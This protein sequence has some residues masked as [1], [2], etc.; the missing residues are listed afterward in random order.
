MIT[1]QYEA[2]QKKST[3]R[4]VMLQRFD[5]EKERWVVLQAPEHGG[6]EVR[7]KPVNLQRLAGA[8]GSRRRLRS[9][10]DI[11]HAATATRP[12]SYKHYLLRL[13]SAVSSLP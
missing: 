10:V 3:H 8:K 4:T 5:R 2:H 12:V 9:P 6:K 11:E 7:V 13:P 1:K